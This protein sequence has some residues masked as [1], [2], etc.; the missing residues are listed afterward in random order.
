MRA[1]EARTVLTI[2]SLARKVKRNRAPARRPGGGGVVPAHDLEKADAQG[3]INHAGRPGAA[4]STAPGA[5]WKRSHHCAAGSRRDPPFANGTRGPRPASYRMIADRGRELRAPV[6]IP[7]APAADFRYSGARRSRAPA[8]DRKERAMR[9]TQGRRWA[10]VGLV[11]AVLAAGLAGASSPAR[12]A[13][14][15]YYLHPDAATPSAA[16]S[17]PTGRATAA[18]PSR[19]T[20]S[21]RSCRRSRH[22]R[23]D[24]HRA[25]FRARRL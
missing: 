23:Q 18:S 2:A 14:N 13:N 11:G 9:Q 15:S 21:P 22:R 1:P 16:P 10:V 4:E 19:A 25:V 3:V 8:R 6:A 12:A 17:G 5:G 20:P 24:L 7:Q